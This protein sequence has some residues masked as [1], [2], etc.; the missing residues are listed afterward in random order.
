MTLIIVKTIRE[1]QK[2]SFEN[3]RKG[4]KTAVV[5]TMGFLHN[6]HLSLIK[7]GKELADIVV[8]TLFV[9]PTQFAPNEDFSKYPR[10]FDKDFKLCEDRGSDYLFF[11]ETKEMYP[12]G[13]S[14]SI[15]IKGI[16]DKFEGEF[17]PSHFSGVATIV[18]KLFNAT[19]PDIAIFGQ[20]DY[21]QTLLI[22]KL[23]DDLNFGIDIVVSETIRE[24]DGLAM[25][26]RNTYL[27]PENRAKAVKIFHSMEAAKKVI[28]EGESGRKIINSALHESLKSVPELKVDYASVA[29]A[30]TLEEPDTFNSGD[31]IVILIAVHLGKTRLIDNSIVKIP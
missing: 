10:D 26:S 25:S 9:N 24:I 13:F 15:E 6:G 1:M 17:R 14:T 19:L 8:T 18:A 16:T 22:K 23:N 29:L 4:L 11:P 31:E 20:K 27:S 7:K 5:P 30:D 2:I 28:K 21:Q 3:K 12:D